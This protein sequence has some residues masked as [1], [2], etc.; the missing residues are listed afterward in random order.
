MR[1]TKKEKLQAAA[2]RQREFERIKF[3][4]SE[5]KNRASS[6]VSSDRASRSVSSNR[7]S[8]PVSSNRISVPNGE[9]PPDN[10]RQQALENILP[11]KTTQMSFKSENLLK[12]LTD[13]SYLP[14]QLIKI[15]LVTLALIS[16]QIVIYFSLL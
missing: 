12:N 2:R 9:E 6:P 3:F 10:A 7:A 15:S 11:S 14:K 5:A 8:G 16:V 1:K 4:L 13:L